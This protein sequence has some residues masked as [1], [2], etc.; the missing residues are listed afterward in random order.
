[1]DKATPKISVITVCYNAGDTLGRAL[2]SLRNQRSKD[3][4]S[5]VVDGLSSDDT[6][7]VIEGYSDVVSQFVSEKDKGIYD[8][9]N[10]GI[11]LAKGDY[12]AFLNADDCYLPDTIERVIKAINEGESPDVVY[13]NLIKE[14]AIEYKMY[15]RLEKPNI[16]RMNETMG[17][18]HPA[19]FC[20]ASLFERFGNFDLRFK[21]AADYHWM[22][23]VYLGGAKF[24]YVDAAL[25]KFSVAGASN[26]SCESY[27]EAATFQKELGLE[28]HESM[29][30]QYGECLRKQKRNRIM[31]MFANLPILKQIYR[32]RIKK[33]WS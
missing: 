9:M 11:A 14:R 26:Q 7:A 2:E 5:I 28:S 13:G 30:A 33:R 19:S 24:Y 32:A 31:L 4:E 23:K 17:I 15:T 3:F 6:N 27:R 29:Q 12:I 1:M 25:A 22:L 16:E 18:F 8:A 10:K 20:R 21:L